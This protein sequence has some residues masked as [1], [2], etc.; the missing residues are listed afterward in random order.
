MTIVAGS[1]GPLPDGGELV[2]IACSGDDA[3]TQRMLERLGS[4]NK[5]VQSALSQAIRR[6]APAGLWRRLLDHL[7]RENLAEAVAGATP[8]VR[9]GSPNRSSAIVKLFVEEDS[10]SAATRQAVLVEGLSDPCGEVRVTAA[11]LLG[12]CG[13]ARAAD[14][15]LDAVQSA[16]PG[17]G[18]RAVDALGVLRLDRSAPTLVEALRS[19]NELLHHAATHALSAFGPGAVP[20]LAGAL[21]APQEHV[22]W[23]AARALGQIGDASAADSL[24]GALGD[25]DSN[26]RFA[27]AEALAEIGCKALPSFLERL[28]RH[29]TSE[30]IR[31]ASRHLINSLHQDDLKARLQPLL[32]VLYAPGAGTQVQIV[33]A[34]LLQAWRNTS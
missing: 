21:R 17:V 22:R 25:P 6:T 23:H 20:A 27:A 2:A 4:P 31:Q 1:V 26:V 10:H 7:A 33:A 30:A 15:L 16:A 8:A 12:M 19:D 11:S 5:A 34:R 18:A 29:A 14:L 9:P 24:A 32:E 28:A 3:A 13:D